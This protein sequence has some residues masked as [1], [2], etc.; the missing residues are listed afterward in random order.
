MALIKR[1]P[2]YSVG[3]ALTV[4]LV[5]VADA[6]GWSGVRTFAVAVGVTAFYVVTILV[7]WLLREQLASVT[8]QQP[9]QKTVSHTNGNG[10][11]GN[12][13]TVFVPGGTVLHTRNVGGL[14]LAPVPPK[15][16]LRASAR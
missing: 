6:R 10:G 14:V 9:E 16:K 5:A 2:V 8:P 7:P 13:P 11:G 15:R 3:L 1:L 12:G 4:A